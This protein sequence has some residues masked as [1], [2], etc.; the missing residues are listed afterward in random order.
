VTLARIV[1]IIVGHYKFCRFGMS[2]LTIKVICSMK[3]D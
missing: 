3:V 2:K 1:K